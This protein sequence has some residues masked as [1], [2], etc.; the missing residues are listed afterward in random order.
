TVV[1][2][3]SDLAL[4]LLSSPNPVLVGNNLT[5][6]FIVTNLG[7]A[8]A[9]SIGLTNILPP[10]VTFISA[11]PSGYVV[12]GSVVTFTNLGSL[13]S[14][15]LGLASIIVKANLAGTLTND[16]SCGSVIT[17]PL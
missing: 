8:T 7:P 1:A 12:S 6:S 15:G 5:Y 17:D 3:T 9:T 2:P 16:A 14:G 4:G 11:T 10:G 13:P